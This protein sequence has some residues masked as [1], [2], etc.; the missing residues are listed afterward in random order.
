MRKGES[1]RE[2]SAFHDVELAEL[3]GADALHDLEGVGLQI[4]IGPGRQLFGTELFQDFGAN[5]FDALQ[6]ELFR[7]LFREERLQVTCQVP[8]LG[9]LA[10]GPEHPLVV[11][12]EAEVQQKNQRDR[13]P[14]E[15]PQRQR[16]RAGLAA[17]RKSLQNNYLTRTSINQP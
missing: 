5:L 12:R 17:D 6:L 3:A 4:G 13:V 8:Q 11:G 14:D 15:F 1:G 2:K 9:Q 16:R 10:H 7:L